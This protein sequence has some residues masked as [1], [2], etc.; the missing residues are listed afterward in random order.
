[1]LGEVCTVAWPELVHSEE[2][3]ENVEAIVRAHPSRPFAFLVLKIAHL[4]SCR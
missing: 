4:E 2:D 1:M 3:S